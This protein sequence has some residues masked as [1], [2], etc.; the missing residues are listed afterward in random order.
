[1]ADLSNLEVVVYEQVGKVA[2]LRMNR[3]E[4][5]NAFNWQMHRDMTR[6]YD[7]INE[8]DDIRSVV[9]TGTGRYFCAGRDL[10]EYLDTY[11]TGETG[12]IRPI[13]NPDHPLF[14]RN[15]TNYPVKKPIVVA[16][17][18][19]V[20]GGGLS[21]LVSM[22]DM[23]VM[24]DD[25]TV[26]DAHARVNIGSISLI[27][28]LPANIAREVAFSDRSLTAEECLRWGFANYVVSKDQV[29]AKA[30]E[31]A[32]NLASMGPDSLRNGREN[33]RTILGLSSDDMSPEAMERKREAAR[34]RI[35]AEKEN[36]DLLEGMRA[37]RDGRKAQYTK[38]V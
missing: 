21:F 38:P 12:G 20:L 14:G 7:E 13:D 37:F 32:A 27:H 1:V 5:L 15:A 30:M 6:C 2:V 26:T 34:A 3:P 23:I 8:N 28:S 9:I 35:A 33:A 25:A 19:H 31:V 36:S 17:N 11:D 10:K 18:G 4:R 22:A 29:M 16:L 24:A